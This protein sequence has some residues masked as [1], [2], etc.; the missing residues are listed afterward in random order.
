[1]PFTSQCFIYI[2]FT[3]YVC[4]MNCCYGMYSVCVCVMHL[5]N[6]IVQV[7]HINRNKYNNIRLN[8]EYILLMKT[9]VGIEYS[10]EITVSQVI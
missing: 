10:N 7:Q 2:L 6:K 4:P 5:W 3:V 9:V 1:M 8:D